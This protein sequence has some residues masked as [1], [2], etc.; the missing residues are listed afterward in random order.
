MLLKHFGL[1]KLFPL[2]ARGCRAT[3]S[4]VYY[5][6][7]VQCFLQALLPFYV[8]QVRGNALPDNRLDIGRRKL[9]NGKKSKPY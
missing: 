9:Q 5:S 8:G 4:L 3:W 1:A 2:V 6:A 7:S